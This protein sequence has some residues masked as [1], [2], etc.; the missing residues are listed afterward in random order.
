[1]DRLSI[2]RRL[3]SLHSRTRFTAERSALRWPEVSQVSNA[4]S[5]RRRP[6]FF[7]YLFPTASGRQS[8]LSPTFYVHSAGMGW[9]P[10]A[11]PESCWRVIRV[12]VEV[13]RQSNS[14]SVLKA[15][16]K[17]IGSN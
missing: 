11:S 8:I 7:K 13:L 2:Q 1:M 15:G 9:K 17:L 14:Y 16:A 10:T 12:E 6:D 3:E 5:R 4:G